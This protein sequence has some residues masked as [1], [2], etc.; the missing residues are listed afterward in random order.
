MA[1]DFYA[2]LRS[3]SHVHVNSSILGATEHNSM[4]SG[5]PSTLRDTWIGLGRVSLNLN[6]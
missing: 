6:R 3:P 1:T 5:L 4:L 2:D